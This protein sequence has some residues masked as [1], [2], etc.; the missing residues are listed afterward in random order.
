MPL[1]LGPG[2]LA[3]L[4]LYAYVAW[5][6]RSA[7]LFWG[8]V[9]VMVG[10]SYLTLV[11]LLSGRSLP[12]LSGDAG[13]SIATRIL[14]LLVASIRVHFVVAGFTNVIVHSIEPALFQ[15]HGQ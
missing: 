11:I 10:T 3:N 13:L 9:G 1:L 2:V 6:I 7:T 14:G 4:I 5:K 15:L 12:R 8:L